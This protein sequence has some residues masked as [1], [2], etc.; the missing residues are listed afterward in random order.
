M[1]YK[2]IICMRT[3]YNV[4]YIFSHSNLDSL[5]YKAQFSNCLIIS[6][7]LFCVRFLSRIV[8]SVY[9]FKIRVLCSLTCMA[10]I[11]STCLLSANQ[12]AFWAT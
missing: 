8:F 2:Q 5:F 9:L 11:N 10:F 3:L 4:Q 7:S 1:S 12:V 6:A